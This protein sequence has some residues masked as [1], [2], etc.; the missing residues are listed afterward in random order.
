MN[1]PLALSVPVT[2]TPSTLTNA[3]IAVLALRFART[4]LSLRQ[5]NEIASLEA[6]FPETGT[7]TQIVRVPFR[8]L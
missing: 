8:M 6:L 1:A 3:R 2:S 5:N 4:K 7:D